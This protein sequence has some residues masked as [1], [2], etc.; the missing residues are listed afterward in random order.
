MLAEAQEHARAQVQRCLGAVR[1]AGPTR[2]V[3]RAL[4]LRAALCDAACTNRSVCRI[5]RRSDVAIYIGRRHARAPTGSPPWRRCA[6]TCAHRASSPTAL[7]CAALGHAMV[8][9]CIHRSVN[10]RAAPDRVDR[11][12]SC[13]H[14]GAMRIGLLQGSKTKRKRTSAPSEP[15]GTP[16]YRYA[17][18]VA[19][20][21]PVSAYPVGAEGPR[22]ATGTKPSLPQ[23]VG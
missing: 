3:H 2:R 16:S 19:C 8:R 10:H 20:E 23:C 5:E 9:W 13:Q 15:K 18:S 11:D 21:F 6:A 12:H 17:C 22:A 7:R 1:T 4:P 14:S